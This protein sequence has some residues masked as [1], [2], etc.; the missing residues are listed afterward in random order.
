MDTLGEIFIKTFLSETFKHLF[1]FFKSTFEKK[2]EKVF[3]DSETAL[4]SHY[5]GVLNWSCRI[6]FLGMSLPIDLNNN[7]IELSINPNIRKYYPK[8]TKNEAITLNES[9]IIKLNENLIILGAPGAGKTTLLKRLIHKFITNTD[10]IYFNKFPVLIKLRELKTDNIFMFISDIIGVNYN[11]V[12]E[13]ISKE[14]FIVRIFVGNLLIENF[15][16]DYLN[17]IGALLFIDG[18]DELNPLYKESFKEQI[19]SLGYKISDARIILTSR[20]GEDLDN[21]SGFSYYQI[22]ELTDSNIKSIINLTSLY[23]EELRQNIIERNYEELCNRPLFLS[24]VILHHNKTKFLPDKPSELYEQIVF[25]MIDEWDKSRKISRQS[26]YSSFYPTKKLDFLSNLSFNLTYIKKKKVFSH[27]DFLD[28]YS[29]IFEKF[30]LPANESYQIALELESHTGI[31][32]ETYYKQYEF[33]HLTIQEYLCANFIVK[34]PFSNLIYQYLDEYPHPIAI[35]VCLSSNPEFYLS[36]IILNQ[37]KEEP[38]S[39]PKNLIIFLERLYIENPQF[40]ISIELGFTFLYL[41]EMLKD[42]ER[43]LLVLTN[44][45]NQPVIKDSMF[46]SLQWYYYRTSTDEQ[47]INEIIKLKRNFYLNTKLI[48]QTPEF[49]SIPRSLII[50]FIQE[51]QLR[52][53]KTN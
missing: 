12:R 4:V 32:Q 29:K 45:F 19:C 53:N 11:I 25:L 41:V 17:K 14:R 21:L 35:A 43:G 22:E 33:S 8:S 31:I 39:N 52:L 42:F 1:S 24:F 5:A 26:K 47:L 34:Q 27:N 44:F 30:N 37:Y 10:E 3:D 36:S 15:L 50:G 13:E 2:P 9:D 20:A 7:T 28:V 18:F 40:Q 23:K 48:I 49:V 16:P 51:K 6:Q 46:K 38:I